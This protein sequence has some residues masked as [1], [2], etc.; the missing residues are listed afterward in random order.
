[1]IDKTQTEIFRLGVIHGFLK[2]EQI[3]QWADEKIAAGSDDY[4]HIRI[5]VAAHSDG[6]ISELNKISGEPDRRLVIHGFFSLLHSY[7]TSWPHEYERIL[8]LLYR[9]MYE[10]RDALTEEEIGDIYLL[11]DEFEQ[12]LLGTSA[13]EVNHMQEALRQFL[14]RYLH[15]TTPTT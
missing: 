3:I 10:Y 6:L 7:Y 14:G 8:P 13:S 12:L 4:D 5:S 11:D 15:R 9:M 2:M 1:M